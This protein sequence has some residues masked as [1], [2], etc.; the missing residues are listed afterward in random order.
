MFIQILAGVFGHQTPEGRV[1]PIAAGEVVEVEDNIGKRLI[2]AGTAAEAI[3]DLPKE[4]T[5]KLQ[6][7]EQQ[8]TA[9]DTLLD[10]VP[11]YSIETTREKLEEIG[12]EFFGI[13]SEELAAA[14]NKAAV[15]A[16]LDEAS[17]ELDEEIPSFNAED[18]IS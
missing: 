14:K 12:R 7:D 3:L 11:E 8:E 1:V 4:L 5:D 15:V 10:D 16:M 6:S 18:A 2:A 13:P 17:A 9:A